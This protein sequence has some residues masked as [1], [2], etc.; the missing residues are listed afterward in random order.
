[1][2]GTNRMVQELM[3]KLG[4]IIV[5]DNKKAAQFSSS[6]GSIFLLTEVFD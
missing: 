5:E 3:V 4:M 6:T 2:Y 1:M